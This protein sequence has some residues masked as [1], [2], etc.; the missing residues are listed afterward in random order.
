MAL[1]EF[2]INNKIYMTTKV[3]LFMA[4][5]RRELRMRVD[6]RKDRESNG[7]CGKNKKG[8]RGSRSSFDQS[9]GGDEEA[10]R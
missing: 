1:A 8:V 5:Y 6:L 3:S 4:N 9:T 2:A 10:S 7:V